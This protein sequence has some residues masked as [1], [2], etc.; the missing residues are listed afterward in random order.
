MGAKP[1][2]QRL[3]E[4]TLAEHLAPVSA[5]RWRCINLA[6]SLFFALVG[7][8]N[9]YVDAHIQQDAWVNF[10]VV[11]VSGLMVIF[12]FPQVFWLAASERDGDPGEVGKTKGDR[13][14]HLLQRA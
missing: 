5:R 3:L 9:I 6:G 1:F 12:M 11:G 7:A 13:L 4:S 8:L 14:T 10:K 2:A